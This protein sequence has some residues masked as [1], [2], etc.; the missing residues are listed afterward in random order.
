MES[1]LDGVRKEATHWLEKVARGLRRDEVPALRAWLASSAHR[2]CILATA[3]LWH[4]PDTVAV[5]AALF[6]I[7]PEPARRKSNR[8]F[9]SGS[10]A[11]AVAAVIVI[12]ATVAINSTFVRLMAKYSPNSADTAKSAVPVDVQIGKPV[13]SVTGPETWDT[14]CLSAGGDTTSIEAPAMTELCA[15]GN[16]ESSGRP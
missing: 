12:T 2:E 14:S 3:R 13:G 6:P 15:P 8:T 5:L 4:G 16:A 1:E 7:E 9:L 10:C 11:V